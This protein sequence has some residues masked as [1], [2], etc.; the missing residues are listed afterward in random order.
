MSLRTKSASRVVAAAL[1]SLVVAPMPAGRA[2]DDFLDPKRADFEGDGKVT[3]GEA[4]VFEILLDTLPVEHPLMA[5]II[6][7]YAS[8]WTAGDPV[9]DLS[10]VF[11]GTGVQSAGLDSGGCDVFIRGDTD[12][13][14]QMVLGD[15]VIIINYLF[16]QGP[17]PDPL[18]SGDTDD[19]G[20]ILIGDAVNLSDYLFSGGDRPPLPH[21][22][23][24]GPYFKGLDPTPDNL[25]NSCDLRVEYFREFAPGTGDA[26][27]TEDG[28]YEEALWI[29]PG[30]K[31]IRLE[32][33]VD[34]EDEPSVIVFADDLDPEPFALAVSADGVVYAV[35]DSEDGDVH[36]LIDTDGD[37]EAD[38]EDIFQIEDDQSE[39][40]KILDAALIDIS[41]GSY[42]DQALVTLHEVD[43]SEFLVI[44]RDSDEDGIIDAGDPVYVTDEV[45]TDPKGLAVDG[46]TGR[47]FVSG[48]IDDVPSVVFYE[49]SDG[50][51][52]VD[53]ATAYVYFDDDDAGGDIEYPAIHYLAEDKTLLVLAIE[54]GEERA[55]IICV[56]DKGGEEEDLDDQV[57]EFNSVS[58]SSYHDF[59][60]DASRP[61]Y[62]DAVSFDESE[63]HYI[64][65]SVILAD[66]W[67]VWE[68]WDDADS[69][70]Y[71]I[72]GW[73]VSLADAALMEA[74]KHRRNLC[75]VTVTSMTGDYVGTGQVRQKLAFTDTHA[76]DGISS[77]S[78]RL[79][80][81]DYLG[82]LATAK[83][84]LSYSYPTDRA[85]DGNSN[86]AVLGGQW[87]TMQG[88]AK[89][90]WTNGGAV[91]ADKLW[92]TSDLM[93]GVWVDQGATPYPAL[94]GR[95]TNY[96]FDGAICFFGGQQQ[97]GN[98]FGILVG[99][100]PA[101]KVTASYLEYGFWY[102]GNWFNAPP[103][104]DVNYDPRQGSWTAG[105][106]HQFGNAVA[107]PVDAGTAFP[108][109]VDLLLDVVRTA[110]GAGNDE[111]GDLADPR[112]QDH[113]IMR[114]NFRIR[115]K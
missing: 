81:A 12:A 16:T 102:G 105:D 78:K 21:G 41:G 25:N 19:D 113:E 83:A 106:A 15:V 115:C 100:N 64:Y 66:Q 39:G 111:Y 1:C 3:A 88:S 48:L 14:G 61:T 7:T 103:G 114:L 101:A 52:V 60:G 69:C 18:D 8:A 62:L 36:V 6:L 91:R 54:D 98:S 5:K 17:A 82:V 77:L 110:G 38:S 2:G 57:Y 24:G 112:F 94:P 99:Y 84:A 11:S 108:M 68:Y 40:L 63:T 29:V 95:R 44:S 20:S 58:R 23:R 107:P 45:L 65:A 51:K 4:K 67:T 109:T 87:G 10:G 50:D 35:T 34:E 42:G 104:W 22:V 72:D 28:D 75:W 92:V 56:K 97:Q 46:R 96:S 74:N 86:P 80:V 90:F 85:S 49:D 89:Y 31:A 13:D 47:V 32:E 79:L 37:G 76:N 27:L 26:D 30:E 59:D 55:S 93:W 73:T 43:G 9:V 53:T 71:E 33:I 70:F